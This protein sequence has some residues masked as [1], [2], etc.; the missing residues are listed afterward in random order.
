[1]I[2]GKKYS[3]K[4]GES[5]KRWIDLVYAVVLFSL[6]YTSYLSITKGDMEKSFWLISALIII[7]I[8][9]ILY[10]IKNR[11]QWKIRKKLKFFVTRNTLFE[12]DNSGKYTY[13][14]EISYY[15]DKESV[16]ISFGLDGSKV[17]EKYRD[18]RQKISDCFNMP[19]IS[20]DENEGNVTYTL[21]YDSYFDPL[22]VDEN[23]DYTELATTE[24]IKLGKHITW[25]IRKSC[26]GLIA[27]STGSGKTYMILYL[28]KCFLA[29]RAEI[30]IIDPKKSDMFKLGRMLGVETA[31]EKNQIAKLLRHAVESMNNRYMDMDQIGADYYTLGL[32]PVVIFF[33]EV[34][35]FSSAASEKERKEVRNYVSAL[36]LKGRQAGYCVLISTQRPDLQDSILTGAIRDQLGIRILLGRNAVSKDTYSMVF[37]NSFSDVNQRFSSSGEGLIYMD[38][39]SQPMDYKAPRLENAW[40]I[41]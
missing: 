21:V 25:N 8:V 28:I 1:M 22:V 20:I 40:V 39:M 29:V 12:K 7:F 34:G 37:G 5:D 2:K 9:S 3:Y 38:G 6:L 27:G 41:K 16:C 35:A 26:H 18:L 4:Y 32:S 24:E 36:I 30:I 33:D 17:S 14:P 11:K 15:V 19:C 31:C 13:I 23:T 10:V